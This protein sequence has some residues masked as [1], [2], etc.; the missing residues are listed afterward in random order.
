MTLDDKILSI[1]GSHDASVTFVDKNG[2]LRVFELERFCNIRYAMY[3]SEFDS[4]SL[5][6]NETIRRNFLSHIKEQIKNTPETVVYSSVLNQND[7]QL[8]S[9]YFPNSCLE[10]FDGHHIS[11]AYGAYYQS[12]FKDALIFTVDGGGSDFGMHTTTKV[13]TGVENEIIEIYKSDLDFGNAYSLIGVP[14]SEIS[15]GKDSSDLG[16]FLSY[17][18]KVMGICAYGEVIEKWIEPMHQFYYHRDLSRLGNDIGLNLSL[19]SLSGQNSYNLAATSQY[20]FENI[21]MDFILNFFENNKKNIVLT[22]GCALN[23]IFNQRL[24]EVLNQKGF[25]LYVP[26]NP[27]DCGQS[28]GQYLVKTK[29]HIDPL[30]YS[31][32]DILDR[33]DLS[34]HLEKGNYNTEEFTTEKIF[35]LI[36]SGKIGGIIQGYSEVGPRALGNRS[37]ICDPSFRDMKDVLNAKVKFRE[38]FRPFAPVCREEDM[39]DY[40]DNAFPSEYMSYAPV[41]KDEYKDKLPSITHN[42]GTARLQTV[43]SKQ[44]KLFYDLLSFMKNCEKIPVI[45]NTSFNI[46]GRPILTTIEDAL[47]VLDNTELDFV[48]IENLLVEK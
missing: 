42:D 4:W 36:S 31:G 24:K 2:D 28:L 7:I 45:L 23:V 33:K 14:M 3:S 41:V 43:N 11:H 44:H 35:N 37:I 48:V 32:F 19:N 21:L 27:N 5:G 1:Y 22:G 34:F 6:T 40:F 13:Y 18:G 15:P 25:D 47:Y 20:V 39:H 16:V 46:K 30:V 9:E 26:P 10:S 29:K 38:W 12:P 8:I 17:A